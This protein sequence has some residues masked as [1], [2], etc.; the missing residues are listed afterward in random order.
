MRVMLRGT[1]IGAKQKRVA[2]REGPKDERHK[3][4]VDDLVPLVAVVAAAHMWDPI[5]APDVTNFRC[6]KQSISEQQTCAQLR[7]L[8]A[9]RRQ[10][11]GWIVSRLP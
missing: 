9:K 6:R 4:E 7:E 1:S 11:R 3:E 2:H 5:S 8:S 10:S